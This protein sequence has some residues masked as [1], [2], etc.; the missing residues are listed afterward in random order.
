MMGCFL[1]AHVVLA[2]SWVVQFIWSTIL[3]GVITHKLPLCTGANDALT[4]LV[5]E[6]SSQ[7]IQTYTARRGKS[8]CGSAWLMQ[9]LAPPDFNVV[10]FLLG[11]SRAGT[12]AEKTSQ[13]G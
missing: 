3:C 13:V 1:I 12:S 5:T 10:L 7:V 4:L 11:F 2:Q 9:V 6:F 8:N